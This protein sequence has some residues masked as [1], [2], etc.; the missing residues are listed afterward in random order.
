MAFFSLLLRSMAL[1]PIQAVKAARP[2]EMQSL[3][4]LSGRPQK[5]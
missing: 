4:T 3:F 1:F 5:L 2:E